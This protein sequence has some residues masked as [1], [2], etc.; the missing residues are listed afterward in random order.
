MSY[1]SSIFPLYFNSLLPPSFFFNNFSNELYLLEK[2]GKEEGDPRV[3]FAIYFLQ[4]M[5]R[6]EGDHLLKKEIQFF[7]NQNKKMSVP[8]KKLKLVENL[9]YNRENKFVALTEGE[10]LWGNLQI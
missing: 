2:E 10:N 3:Y 6:N 8:Q 1:L 5:L 9:N 4:K 7:N